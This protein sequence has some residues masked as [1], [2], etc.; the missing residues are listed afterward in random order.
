MVSSICIFFLLSDCPSLVSFIASDLSILRGY[1][2]TFF[3]FYFFRWWS[4][5][6]SQ[7]LLAVSDFQVDTCLLQLSSGP[8]CPD[9]LSYVFS[10]VAHKHLRFNIHTHYPIISSKRSPCRSLCPIISLSHYSLCPIISDSISP[11]F[12][13]HPSLSEWLSNL[14][15][16][17]QLVSCGVK[18]QSRVGLTPPHC[19]FSF[20]NYSEVRRL[21]R[22]SFSSWRTCNKVQRVLL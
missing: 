2:Y 18:I 12:V 20:I 11:S 6:R 17:T 5:S 8:P 10:W 19:A 7:N 14:P 15:K 9:Y 16:V 1:P 4:H 3:S 22:P 21:I 13:N